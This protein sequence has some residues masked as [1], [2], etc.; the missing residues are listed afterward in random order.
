MIDTAHLFGLRVVA[1]GVEDQ[2]SLELLRQMGCDY[3]QGYFFTPP[4]PAPEF[5]QWVKNWPGL[6]SL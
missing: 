4:L 5:E 1:E 3:A 6:E 2:A